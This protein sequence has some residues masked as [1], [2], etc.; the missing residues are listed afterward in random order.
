MRRVAVLIWISHRRQWRRNRQILGIVGGPRRGLPPSNLAR[1]DF[2]VD[3]ARSVSIAERSAHFDNRSRMFLVMRSTVASPPR[4][5]C[6]QSVL[7]QVN[8]VPP[9]V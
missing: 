3:E 5:P 4:S 1:N 7:P 6:A 9:R 2:A 8:T